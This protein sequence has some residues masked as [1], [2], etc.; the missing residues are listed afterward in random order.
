MLQACCRHVAGMLQACCRHT[1]GGAE[2]E[3]RVARHGAASHDV[4]VRLLYHPCW[5]HTHTHVNMRLQ[6]HACFDA[7]CHMLGCCLPHAL[8]LR[9]RVLFRAL[10][11]L[12]FIFI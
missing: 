4:V 10:Q 12:F 5:L 7:A 8:H 2:V 9:T 3:K 11:T 1:I 6:Y